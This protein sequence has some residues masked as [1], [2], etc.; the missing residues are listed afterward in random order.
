MT[1]ISY[2]QNAYT[3]NTGLARKFIRVFLLWKI[4]LQIYMLQKS[5]VL[6]CIK[7]N[8]IH[9]TYF[10]NIFNTTLLIRIFFQSLEYMKEAASQWEKIYFVLLLE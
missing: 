7:R 3:K 6:K 8:S 2:Y 4:T 10:N 9:T 1:G 5:Y